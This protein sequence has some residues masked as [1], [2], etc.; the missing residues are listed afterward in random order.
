MRSSLIFAGVCVLGLI[1]GCGGRPSVER[2]KH[3]TPPP[4]NPIAV[5]AKGAEAQVTPDAASASPKK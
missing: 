1:L 5:D 4:K 3:P 2:P